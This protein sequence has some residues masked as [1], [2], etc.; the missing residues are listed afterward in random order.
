MEYIVL[1]KFGKYQVGNVVSDDDFYIRRKLEEG[2][3]LEEKSIKTYEN[4][5]VKPKED[6]SEVK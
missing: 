4:K 3:C 6:K 5:A 1:K 2:G